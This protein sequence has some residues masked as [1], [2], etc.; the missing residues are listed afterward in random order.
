MAWTDSEGEAHEHTEPAVVADHAK[1]AIRGTLN[2]LGVTPAGTPRFTS[3]WDGATITSF[4]GTD[5]ALYR[6]AARPFG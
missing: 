1:T 3:T 4:S 5:G 6:C 2:K